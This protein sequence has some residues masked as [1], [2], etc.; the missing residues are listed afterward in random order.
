MPVLGF[1]MLTLSVVTVVP[2]LVATD[3]GSLTKA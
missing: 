2:L 3:G 1:P